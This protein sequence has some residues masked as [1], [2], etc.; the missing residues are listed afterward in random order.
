MLFE[1]IEDGLFTGH[2]KNGVKVFAQGEDLHNV[3]C[4]V[5]ITSVLP[6]GLR[7]EIERRV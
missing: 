3:L 7:G 6:E 1:Q 2:A 4:R 5:R